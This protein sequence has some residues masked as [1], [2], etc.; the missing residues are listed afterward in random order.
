MYRGGKTK[1]CK[2]QLI[3]K[4]IYQPCGIICRYLII[5]GGKVGLVAVRSCYIIHAP[6]L[7][8]CMQLLTLLTLCVYFS[9]LWVFPK[10]ASQLQPLVSAA[11]LSPDK[12]HNSIR[13]PSLIYLN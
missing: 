6:L 13:I 4:S 9:P 8:N 12:R 3:Y 7:A 5:K 10:L 1:L 11:A 2:L